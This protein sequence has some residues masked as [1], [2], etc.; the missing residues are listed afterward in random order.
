MATEHVN[1]EALIQGIQLSD[2]RLYQILQELNRG[3]LYVQEELFPLVLEAQL[4]PPTVPLLDSP[5][6]FTYQ[7]TPITVRLLWSEVP[8]ATGYEVR[9]GPVWDTALFMFRNN[10]IQADISPLLLGTHIF[11]IKTINSAGA[12]SDASTI[13]SITIPPLGTITIDKQVI[14]NNVLLRWTPPTSTFRIL[15]YEVKKGTT[16]IG[17]VDSTFF[18]FFENVAGTFTY[19]ITAIDVAGN[20]SPTASVVVT[21]LSPPDYALQD[22]RV[23]ALNGTTVNVY[24]SA[25]LPSLLAC[26]DIHAWA[27][28]FER[29]TWTQIQNQI[30]AGYPIYIQPTVLTGSYTEIIDYGVLIHNTIVTVTWNQTIWTPGNEVS[31]NVKMLVSDDGLTYSAPSYGASQYFGQLRYLQLVLEFTAPNDKALLEI[32]NLTTSLNVKR[33]NDG[34]EVNALATDV[35]GTV[36]NF[37]KSF[38]DIESITATTKSPT[39]PFVVIFDFADIPNPVFFKVFVFDTMGARVTRTVDWKARGIV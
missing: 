9:E 18:T 12:Y 22:T 11:E 36:V 28:H 23:S 26:V 34:G 21:V 3:L 30:D 1:V 14:D 16:T 27:V 17:L 39:E 37:T 20:R 2:P 35:G 8:D 19:Q 38:R 6:S 15:N 25:K 24:R 31:V 10:S 32:Y 7:F 29:R 33:E 13:Q 4:P 5:A